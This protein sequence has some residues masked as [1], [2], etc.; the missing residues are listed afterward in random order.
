MRVIRSGKF[1]AE[2]AW[3]AMNIANMNGITTKLHWTDK[4]TSGTSMKGKKCLSC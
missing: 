2:E 3:G 4:P 1:T